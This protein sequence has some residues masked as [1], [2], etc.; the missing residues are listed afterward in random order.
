MAF[1]QEAT[2]YGSGRRTAMTLR[3]G[4]GRQGG[5][6]AWSSR[7]KEHPSRQERGTAEFSITDAANGL[8]EA[9]NY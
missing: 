8:T 7:I 3:G 1:F 9:H 5:G 4:G 2:I 6:V